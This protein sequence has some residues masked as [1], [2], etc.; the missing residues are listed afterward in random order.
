[1]L[2]RIS[3]HNEWETSHPTAMEEEME[4]VVGPQL[5][6]WIQLLEYIVGRTL[7]SWIVPKEG[8]TG[9]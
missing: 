6:Y 2:R 1:M 9:Q 7:M 8:K 3:F 5:E 4:I